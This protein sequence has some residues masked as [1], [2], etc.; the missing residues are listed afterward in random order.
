MGL[1][2]LTRDG[3]LDTT[4]DVYAQAMSLFREIWKPPEGNAFASHKEIIARGSELQEELGAALQEDFLMFEGKPT[5][6]A[7]AT[8]SFR[9][10]SRGLSGIG[11]SSSA[12]LQPP[13]FK[14]CDTARLEQVRATVE[15]L[16]E[17]ETALRLHNSTL[18]SICLRQMIRIKELHTELSV[19]SEQMATL[20]GQQHRVAQMSADYADMMVSH[21][22]THTNL[23]AIHGEL[24]R[25]LE[26]LP[27]VLR[28]ELLGT[29][30]ETIQHYF[31][32]NA[33]PRVIM[34]TQTGLLK[35]EWDK[36][37]SDPEKDSGQT[38]E[39]VNAQRRLD[40]VA[41]KA[42]VQ[43]LK[44]SSLMLPWKS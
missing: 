11:Q 1:D 39:R 44:I 24:H 19:L 43:T 12:V 30:E 2:A 3:P 37:H 21:A 23:L 14:Q 20:A 8:S 17:S 13:N 36:L 29:D 4:T 27:T 6:T 31:A 5:A 35:V 32:R 26:L 28:K 41:L 34:D 25:R 33:T 10:K 15:A 22:S 16:L 42:R 9:R 7:V 38:Q 18:T 40:A